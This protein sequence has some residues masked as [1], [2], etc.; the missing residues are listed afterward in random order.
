MNFLMSSSTAFTEP[1]PQVLTGIRVPQRFSAW[2]YDIRFVA[3]LV[4]D[5][6]SHEDHALYATE[7]LAIYA[8]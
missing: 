5:V 1:S 6:P 4:I 7:A 3:R 8:H 2:L